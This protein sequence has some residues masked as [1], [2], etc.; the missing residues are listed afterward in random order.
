MSSS[1]TALVRPFAMIVQ[2][3][4]VRVPGQVAYEL[5]S[6]QAAPMVHF[7]ASSA[8]Q[9]SSDPAA[10][11]QAAV[12][13]VSHMLHGMPLFRCPRCL[14]NPGCGPGA[15]VAR[16]MRRASSALCGERGVFKP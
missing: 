16:G 1:A 15:V 14:S 7:V 4:L 12:G 6:G 2:P 10:S 5:P 9:M 11:E 3:S 8:A 13:H